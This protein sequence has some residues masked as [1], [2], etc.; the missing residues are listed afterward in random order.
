MSNGGG[1]KIRLPEH[2]EGLG[3]A[4]PSNLFNLLTPNL[5]STAEVRRIPAIA[6][7]ERHERVLSNA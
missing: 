5:L 6:P 2:R 4:G 1:V 7:G 3:G